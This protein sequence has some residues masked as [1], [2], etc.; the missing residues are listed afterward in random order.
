MTTSNLINPPITPTPSIIHSITMT[1]STPLADHLSSPS[2]T[3]IILSGQI[4][5]L[6]SFP[7]PGLTDIETNTPILGEE[8]VFGIPFGP[9][10]ERIGDLATSPNPSHATFGE[11]SPHQPSPNSTHSSPPLLSTPISETDIP[12]STINPPGFITYNSFNPNHKKYHV[13]IPQPDSTYH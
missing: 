12:T 11:D 9:L 7:S 6:E 13:D 3:P 10:A 4:S 8:L 2:L 1:S 5:T